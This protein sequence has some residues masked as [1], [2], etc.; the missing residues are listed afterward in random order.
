MYR[1]YTSL[2]VLSLIATGTTLKCWI[3]SFEYVRETQR[4]LLECP[5]STQEFCEIVRAGNNHETRGCDISIGNIRK[6]CWEDGLYFKND[7][8][9]AVYC[10][11]TD[12]CNDKMPPPLNSSERVIVVCHYLST[13]V[14][15]VAFLLI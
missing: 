10:C 9:T 7:G 13:L 1:R 11:S 4:T 8:D 5:E 12:F 3:S 15:M 2:V 14:I 6:D